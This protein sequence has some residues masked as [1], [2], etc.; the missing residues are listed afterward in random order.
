MSG[1]APTVSVVMAVYNEEKYVSMA[2]ES[3]LEQTFSDFEFL[4]VDDG[5]TDRTSEIVDG[6][7]KSDKPRTIAY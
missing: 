2:I 5:S 3:I 4:I 1:Q 6:Y 7:A